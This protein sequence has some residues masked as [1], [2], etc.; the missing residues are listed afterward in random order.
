[1]YKLS[2]IFLQEFI[3]V[4]QLKGSTQ[5]KILC[6]QGPPGVGKTSI[7]KSIARAL[8]REVRVLKI[9]NYM[10]GINI[11]VKSRGAGHVNFKISLLFYRTY[12]NYIKLWNK[13]G[14][15]DFMFSRF[16]GKRL[17]RWIKYS[18]KKQESTVLHV[19]QHA[20]GLELDT[21]SHTLI[22]IPLILWIW[23]SESES[24][25]SQSTSDRNYWMSFVMVPSSLR[26]RCLVKLIKQCTSSH[27]K[28]YF[29]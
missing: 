23:C 4:S 22:S 14:N 12:V 7:A 15:Q 13:F 10:R 6:F 9:P 2:H 1:M 20:D 18:R 29:I 16:G 27:F 19:I 11:S 21:V 8:G 5:G 25:N 3:A 17:N 24:H 28:A 26:K